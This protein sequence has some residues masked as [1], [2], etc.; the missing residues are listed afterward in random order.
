MN[1]KSAQRHL[2][3]LSTS[4]G[5]DIKKLMADDDVIEIMVNP[6]GKLW[7][8]SLTRGKYYTEI[9]FT[10]NQV[11]NMI[12]LVATHRQMIANQDHPEVACELPESG[13]RFQGWLPPVVDQPS[14]TMRKKA[15][16]IFTLDDYVNAKSLTAKQAETIKQAIKNRK[17]ILIAGSTA[18]GKT[19]FANALLNELKNSNERIIVLEDLPELQVNVDDCIKLRTSNTVSM[20][21]LVKG[22]LRMRP[23]RIIV[24]EVRDGAALELLKAWNTGH[25]GGICTIHSN[26]LKSTLSRIEDL[27]QEAVTIVPTRLIKEAINYIVYM[28]RCKNNQYKVENI[29][30]YNDLT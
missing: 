20:H 29:S 6:D 10:A 30:S 28:H 16:R 4:F 2:D 18:S 23:D 27:V 13:A 9:I 3:M 25:P 19:T 14:F 8:D 17:N 11:A 12:K 15:I 7:V 22:S 1:Q 5:N 21:D 26:S 24:G